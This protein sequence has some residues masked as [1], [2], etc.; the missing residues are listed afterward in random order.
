MTTKVSTN[1]FE[2]SH[3]PG[4]EATKVSEHLFHLPI[5]GLKPW[6]RNART[7]SMKQIKQIAKS[8]DRFGFTNPVLVDDDNMILAGHGRVSAAKHLGMIEVPCLRLSDM[9]EA[10]KRAYVLADNKLALNTGWD[11]D[12]L[13]TELQILLRD[14]DDIDI[15]LTGFDI[16]EIDTLLE[17][18]GTDAA[19]EAEEDDRIP[20]LSDQKLAVTQPG[21]LWQLDPHRMICGDARE[22]AVYAQLMRKADGSLDRAEMI[23]TD[24]P[25][26][27][28]INGHVMGKGQIKHRE[29]AC[30]SVEMSADAFTDFLAS[31]F[32][33]LAEHSQ[34]GSIHF[35]CM[36]WRH[37]NEI[38][39]AGT[40]I[41][42]ELKNLTVWVKDNGGMGS[43]Y[44]SRHELIF[45]F[46]KGTAPHVNSFELGQ[47]GRYRTNV[48]NYKGITSPTKA[49][50][51]ELAL[52]PTVKPVAMVADAIKD[53]SHRG[54]IILDAFCGSGTI[55]VAA[56][57]TGR[58]A[59]A[60]EIDPLYCDTAIKRWQ[61]FA[62]DDAILVE[63]GETFAEVARRRGIK[64]IELQANAGSVTNSS[65]H[66]APLLPP[67]SQS[68]QQAASP[69][70]QP[71]S[72][73]DRVCDE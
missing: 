62:H 8:I 36:D 68:S 17:I 35:V 37:M 69:W 24:P 73:N 4:M 50:R 9:S 67:P 19:T 56:Q 54:S 3:S 64:A 7:H 49:S 38:K 60:I 42:S 70:A 58:K 5:S 44:R 11:E 45:V 65:S 10:E 66:E 30:A 26:N 15:Q 48:W 51:E 57:K 33:R 61:V 71:S 47:H 25:Y 12:I 46:K 20:P 14:C 29:F 34:D 1:S 32:V 6:P 52:H 28:P 18:G 72:T 21:D 16:P 55:L 53:C 23:F 31:V 22:D 43:F 27:V 13:A 41:Y 59:R 63:T 40:D 39:S 2:S